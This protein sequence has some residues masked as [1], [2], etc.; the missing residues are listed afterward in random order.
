V[1]QTSPLIIV[2]EGGFTTHKNLLTSTIST[3][4]IYHSISPFLASALSQH[5]LY[6]QLVNRD[7]REELKTAT[8]ERRRRRPQP[9]AQPASCRH[10]TRFGSNTGISCSRARRAAAAASAPGREHTA[11]PRRPQSIPANGSCCCTSDNRRATRRQRAT[12]HRAF[13][14]RRSTRGGASA[15]SA[16]ATASEGRRL[17]CAS[18]ANGNDI[19]HLQL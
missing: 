14:C 18:A 9:S 1:I 16:T 13:R 15:G 2:A 6:A 17:P 7:G 19:S 5:H 12:Q 8:R 3:T 10:P 4:R 11:A